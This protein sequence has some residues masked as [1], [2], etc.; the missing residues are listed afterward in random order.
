MK[1]EILFIQSVPEQG[2]DLGFP[3]T[4]LEAWPRLRMHA[5]AAHCVMPQP[6]TETSARF[7]EA[8]LW[9]KVRMEARLEKGFDGTGHGP[10]SFSQGVDVH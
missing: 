1:M 9:Q 5:G 10:A 6:G 7:G 4:A 2:S 3:P 8:R